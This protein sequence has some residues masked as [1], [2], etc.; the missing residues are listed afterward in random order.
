MPWATSFRA[1]LD[2]TIVY[3]D[4]APDFRDFLC[5]RLRRV[6]VRVQSLP[7]PA[8]LMNNDYAGDAATREAF[9]KWVQQLWQDK[10]AQIS[11]RADDEAGSAQQEIRMLVRR[12]R[13]VYHAIFCSVLSALLVCMVVAGAFLGALL[14]VDLARTVASLFIAAMLA[15]IAGLSL[16][17]REVY[18]AVRAGTHNQP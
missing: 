8:H 3:P 15:M 14:G 11:T 17:L 4:G 5:G 6:I 9:A 12:S 2:V 18:L 10:D 7:V 1:I 16:F 13:L